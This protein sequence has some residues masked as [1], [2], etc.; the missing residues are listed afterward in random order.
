MADISKGLSQMS[1]DQ[2]TASQNLIVV[3][4]DVG[5]TYS[6]YAFSF[7]NKPS[8]V[9]V[10]NWENHANNG[11]SYKAPSVLLLNQTYQFVAFGYEAEKQYSDIIT[12]EPTDQ[13]LFVKNFKTELVNDRGL[14]RHLLVKD[15]LHR[16]IPAHGLFIE[17]IRFL[18]KHFL[19]TLKSRGLSFKEDDIKYIVTIPAMWTDVA[20]QIMR[21]SAG[22]AGIKPRNLE[23]AF[24]PE[25]AAVHC[26]HI[27]SE[28]LSGI[29]KDLKEMSEPG[30]KFAVLDLGGGTA[31]MTIEQNT[32]DG[33][34]NLVHKATGGLWGGDKVNQEF[35][36]FLRNVVGENIFNKFIRENILD[37]LF[38]NGQFETKKRSIRKDTE[39]EIVLQLPVSLCETYVE[40]TGISLA[41]T[42]RNSIHSRD[43]SVMRGRF[44]I[45][46]EKCRSFFT[47][48]II[49]I[50][51]HA[52]EMLSKPEYQDVKHI[53][54][55]GGF[56]ESPLVIDEMRSCF[57]DKRV[58]VPVDAGLSVLKGAVLYGHNTDI[59]TSRP[60][61]LTYG[62][63]LYDTFD[64]RKH[65][66]TKSVMVG[67][68]RFV[69]GLFEKVFTIN[70]EV[71]IGSKRSIGVY[72]N[73]VGDSDALRRSTKEIE[74]FSSS[75][76]NPR[77]VTDINCSRHG[78]LVVPPPESGWPDHVKGQVEFEFGATELMIRYV[79]KNSDYTVTGSVDFH[80]RETPLDLMQSSIRKQA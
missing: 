17:T 31:D 77:Y 59:I 52:K 50:I 9:T 80:L 56:S 14:Q 4:I 29:R 72:E 28:N 75:D 47:G 37:F 73:Y 49:G 78:C 41:E 65:D 40:G 61:P 55:V 32:L 68:D 66:M 7:R 15:V 6:G 54:M 76:P 19:G 33:K 44:N 42:I 43:I 62:L 58:I 79:D 57:P 39:G 23:L 69:L 1:I 26:M 12:K 22:V 18:R 45:S 36:K 21:E 13:Y 63:S 11:F 70:E 2:P 25:V 64:G 38:I 34:I 74:I 20:K 51:E 30:R 10:V 53:L 35:S 67:R 46:A 60:S 5:T 27:P 16:F 71:K 48:A 3:A 8:E 24:E